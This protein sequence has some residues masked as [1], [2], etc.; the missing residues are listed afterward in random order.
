MNNL[1]QAHGERFIAGEDKGRPE[2]N[3]GS[4]GVKNGGDAREGSS[5]GRSRDK[6]GDGVLALSRAFRRR[7]GQDD[8]ASPVGPLMQMQGRLT[9]TVNRVQRGMKRGIEN[10]E[11]EGSDERNSC[12]RGKPGGNPSDGAIVRRKDLSGRLSRAIALL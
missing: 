3:A 12:L 10:K 9:T 2:H 4:P 11:G 1:V 8:A 5:R 7:V 6:A